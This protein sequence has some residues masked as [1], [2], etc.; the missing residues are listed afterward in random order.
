MTFTFT[1]KVFPE[2]QEI[3]EVSPTSAPSHCLNDSGLQFN[4]QRESRRGQAD[5]LSFR[6]S[7]DGGRSGEGS[8]DRTKNSNRCTAFSLNIKQR[9]DRHRHIENC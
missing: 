4:R 6:D 7:A 8:I 5:L 3:N 9:T 2:R 1:F